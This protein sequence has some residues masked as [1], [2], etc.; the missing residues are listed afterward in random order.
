MTTISDNIPAGFLAE[1]EIPP[2][3]AKVAGT[4]GFRLQFLGNRALAEKP[5]VGV[6]GSRRASENS[7]G[8]M[9]ESVAR[10]VENGYVIVSGNAGGVDREAHLTALKEGGETILVLPHGISHF[11][12]PL[13]LRPVWDWERALVV[14]EFPEKSGWS[15]YNAMRR[16]RTIIGLSRALVVTEAGEKGGTLA[17]GEEAL[18]V[19]TPLHV[20]QCWETPA[21]PGNAT[22]LRKGGHAI[23]KKRESGKPNL[24]NLLA[25]VVAQGGGRFAPTGALI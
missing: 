24:E 16:N 23:R 3:L 19:G 6:C 9:R 8:L 11:R 25:D 5:G 13:A 12:V 1:G 7:I 14:S 17:A 18:R 22:L 15:V 2:R 10:I 21:A 20:F 4:G